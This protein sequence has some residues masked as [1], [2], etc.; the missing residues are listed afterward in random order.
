MYVN[1]KSNIPVY[2]QLKR[3]ILDKIA[4]EEYKTDNPI[5]SERELG[6]NIGV[7]RMTVRQALNQLVAEGVLY[8]EK[9]RG[10]FVSKPKFEQKFN[11][12]FSEMVRNRGMTPGTKILEFKR[13]IPSDI[14]REMLGMSV[15]EQI[16]IIKRI[17]YANGKPIGIDQ[18]YIPVK[19]CLGMEKFDLTGSLYKL[20]LEEYSYTITGVDNT[21]EAARPRKDEREILGINIETPVL[22]VYSVYYTETIQKLYYEKS[23]FRSDEYKFSIKRPY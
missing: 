19:Y 6:E 7:S 4:C 11:M 2:Q 21:I 16:Y 1:K 8:R 22:I 14:V 20:L 5:P 23:V 18:E 9:G 15:E 13:E 12:S 17:R 3:I 10:T